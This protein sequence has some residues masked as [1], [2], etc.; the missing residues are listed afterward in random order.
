[1]L[2]AVTESETANLTNMIEA[3][4]RYGI[5]YE[6]VRCSSKI[7]LK[8]ANRWVAFH[9]ELCIFESC[10]LSPISRNSDLSHLYKLN[11]IKCCKKH[12]LPHLVYCNVQML[13]Q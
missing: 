3:L 13:L 8:Y 12:L 10:F 5:P 2:Q 11:K 6:K 4:E 9:E 7:S 1:M